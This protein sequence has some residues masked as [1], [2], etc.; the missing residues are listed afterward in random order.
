[1]VN[2]GR[3]RWGTTNNICLNYFN[4]LGNTRRQCQFHQPTSKSSSRDLSQRAL[5]NEF[6]HP[7]PVTCPLAP[8]RFHVKGLRK[9]VNVEK[10][11]FKNEMWK[12]I[13]HIDDFD[14]FLTTLVIWGVSAKNQKNPK[15]TIKKKLKLKKKKNVFF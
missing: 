13:G 6:G 11:I 5:A 4:I 1:M 8:G 3:P 2:L 12:I 10:G 14:R 9:N 7:S 15:I